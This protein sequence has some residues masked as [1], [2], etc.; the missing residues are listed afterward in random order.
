MSSKFEGGMQDCLS[1]CRLLLPAAKG[2]S[3][4]VAAAAAAAAILV[5]AHTLT[6][7]LAG[8]QFRFVFFFEI[9]G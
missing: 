3:F 7:T 6:H 2:E 1:S 8:F 4:T 9:G 5:V